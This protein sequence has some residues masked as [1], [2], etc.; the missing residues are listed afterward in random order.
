MHHLELRRA[1]H[2][3]VHRNSTHRLRAVWTASAAHGRRHAE[4]ALR[5]HPAGVHAG[6][7]RVYRHSLSAFAPTVIALAVATLR[8]AH[9]LEWVAVQAQEHI[10]VQSGAKAAAQAYRV[11]RTVRIRI[12][13]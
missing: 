12:F 2:Q 13:P 9:V 5:P 8:V 11:V 7:H 6:V 10:K 4:H 1:V 3:R